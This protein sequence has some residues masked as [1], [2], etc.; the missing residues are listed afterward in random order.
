MNSCNNIQ[1]RTGVSEQQDLCMLRASM[2]ITSSN[3]SCPKSEVMR[4]LSSLMP[5]EGDEH[6]PKGHHS[7][8]KIGT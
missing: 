1:G 8:S 5:M 6:H 7:Q 4:Y 2:E 3:S